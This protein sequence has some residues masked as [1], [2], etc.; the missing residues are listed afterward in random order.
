MCLTDL[1]TGFKVGRS[2]KDRQRFH[3]LLSGIDEI[4]K[5]PCPS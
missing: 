4:L 2:F 1:K 3:F 5:Q